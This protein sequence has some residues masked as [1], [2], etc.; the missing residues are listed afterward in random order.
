MSAE[1]AERFKMACAEAG[2]P[3]VVVVP[4]HRR[5]ETFSWERSTAPPYEVAWRALRLV[6]TTD[7][8]CL[9]CW[10]SFR[11]SHECNARG[12]FVDDCGADR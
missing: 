1:L 4:S 6:G 8:P 3:N 7:T 5:G 11:Q 2:Y 9:N 12:E 10:L